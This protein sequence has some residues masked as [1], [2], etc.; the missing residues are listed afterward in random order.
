[1]QRYCNRRLTTEVG[2]TSA[3]C[4]ELV[5]P[6][7][8]STNDN[9]LLVVIFLGTNDATLPFDTKYHVPL[10][11]YKNNLK[12]MIKATQDKRPNAKILL[13]TPPPIDADRCAQV[14]KKQGRRP[15]RDVQTTRSYRDACLDVGREMNV[16]V[17][18]TWRLFLGE[19]I[20][21][22]VQ[23]LERILSDG[24]HLDVIGNQILGNAVIDIIRSEWAEIAPESLEMMVPGHADIDV[25]NLKESLYGNQN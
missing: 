1:M 22:R 23:T 19:E 5:E 2:Y 13:I 7:L 15:D 17:L 20:E 8:L 25:D 6:L 14:R 9:L 3:W 18:D 12:K 16:S 10:P 4:A 11:T 21:H 24:L